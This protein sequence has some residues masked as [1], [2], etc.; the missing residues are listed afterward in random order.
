MFVACSEISINVIVKHVQHVGIVWA[1]SLPWVDLLNFSVL[2]G[3]EKIAR[4]W[5]TRNISSQANIMP[6]VII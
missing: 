2:E 6:N 5:Y 1:C 4:L 3:T